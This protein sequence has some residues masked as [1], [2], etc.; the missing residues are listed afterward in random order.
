MHTIHPPGDRTVQLAV[1]RN[2]FLS[3]IVFS[4]K[5]GFASSPRPSVAATPSESTGGLRWF[6]IRF[7]TARIHRPIHRL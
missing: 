7:P 2:H 5:A 3:R 6:P 1:A 4:T